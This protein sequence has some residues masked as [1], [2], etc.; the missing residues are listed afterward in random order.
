[1]STAIHAPKQLIQ[2]HKEVFLISTLLFLI[3][4]IVGIHPQYGKPIIEHAREIEIDPYAVATN[5][6]SIFINNGLISLILCVGWFIFP[7]YPDCFPITVMVYNVGS[8]FGAVLAYANI[9]QFFVSILTFGLIEALGFIFGLSAGLLLP[10]YAIQRLLGK[11]ANLSTYL[12]D[13]LTFMLYSLSSLVISAFLE[14]VLLHP[15]LFSIAFII[16]VICT[17]AYLRYFIMWEE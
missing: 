5:F 2:K 10:K 16:G 7:F 14:A 6:K 17:F 4:V 13:S 15:A 12:L 3:G 9:L 8:A 11:P 1:L